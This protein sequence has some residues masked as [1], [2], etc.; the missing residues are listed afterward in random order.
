MACP[1]QFVA[2]T[3]FSARSICNRHS[4]L[5][6]PDCRLQ[7]SDLN[8]FGGLNEKATATEKSHSHKGPA[9]SL[10]DH[11]GTDLAMPLDEC[12]IEVQGLYLAVCKNRGMSAVQVQSHLLDNGPGQRQPAGEP[13]IHN[14]GGG[15]EDLVATSDFDRYPSLKTSG[16]IG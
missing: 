8:T 10:V 14:R 1:V 3:S 4:T 5:S 16:T 12:K 9:T 2:A 7:L 15:T 11:H 6:S 13:D